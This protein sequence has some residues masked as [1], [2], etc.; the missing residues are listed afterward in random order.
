MDPK[1]IVEK[2]LALAKGIEGAYALDGSDPG[3]HGLEDNEFV[4][5]VGDKVFLVRVEDR[6]EELSDP[7]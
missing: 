4:I 1:E 3:Y 6:T 2:L 5:G 7:A